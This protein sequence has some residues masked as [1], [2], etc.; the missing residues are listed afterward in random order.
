MPFFQ[1]LLRL[2]KIDGK[3]VLRVYVITWDTPKIPVTNWCKVVATGMW[4]RLNTL[5]NWPTLFGQHLPSMNASSLG[6]TRTRFQKPPRG[7]HGTRKY[8]T[9]LWSLAH[10]LS[11]VHRH[12]NGEKNQF[13]FQIWSSGSQGPPE[14]LVVQNCTKKGNKSQ[15]CISEGCYNSKVQFRNCFSE[16]LWSLRCLG[17]P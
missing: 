13:V 2:N 5:I 10:F 3:I 12:L 1:D 11:T 17:S 4:P 16:S 9:I 6:Q 8:F 7:I 14:T 15:A